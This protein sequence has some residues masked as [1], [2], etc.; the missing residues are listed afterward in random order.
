ME[1]KRSIDELKKE[2]SSIKTNNLTLNYNNGTI[3]NN[4]TINHIGPIAPISH[5]NNQPIRI[6]T[7]RKTRIFA[8]PHPTRT[9]SAKSLTGPVRLSFISVAPSDMLKDFNTKNAPPH[10]DP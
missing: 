4:K 8:P 5:S 1:L 2:I 7:S 3:N 6:T 10:K 9:K